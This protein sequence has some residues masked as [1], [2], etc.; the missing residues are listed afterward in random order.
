[1]SNS[2]ST[3]PTLVDPSRTTA[4]QTIRSTEI[5]RL[6]DLQ[7]YIFATSGTHNVLSQ[8]YDD[9]CFIQDATSFT[10]MSRWIIPRISRSHNELK[11]RLSA[12]CSTAGAQVRLTLSFL[13]SANTYTA[14]ITVTDTGRYSSGFD[15]ATITTLSSE[16]EEFA[17]LTLEAKAP[18]SDEVEILGIQANWSPISSPLSAGLHYQG[19]SEF[20]PVGANRQGD[21]L[22][23]TSRFGVDALNN[24]ETLR[25]RG[26]TLVCWSG[27]EN[28]SSSQSL[29]F[30]ANPPIGLGVGDNG[31]LGSIVALPVGMNEID[32]LSINLFAYVVG[33]GAG[34]SITVEIFN[35][36]MTFS[37]NG[38]NSYS[39]EIF[40]SDL[41]LSDEF[42][43]SVY[44]VEINN[45]D[46]NLQSLLSFNNPVS[47]SPFISSLSIIGV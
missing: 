3:S 8:T 46:T 5:S 7:N 47:S 35:H 26:R 45:N 44:R 20:V 18:A 6:A 29:Q 9:S 28:A 34:Q 12:F 30:A 1:M 13:I 24:I 17:I 21:D 37:F 19:T 40:G 14:T 31:V 22:P 23:L 41:N 10:T 33:L 42:G 36:R 27:V 11:V 43:L 25:K 16:T 2:F 38:W 15:V 39:L 32:G 4:T